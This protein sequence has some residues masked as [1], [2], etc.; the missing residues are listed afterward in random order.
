MTFFGKYLPTEIPRLNCAIRIYGGLVR[1]FMDIQI[2]LHYVTFF[3]IIFLWY[4]M[5]NNHCQLAIDFTLLGEGGD[6]KPNNSKGKETSTLLQVTA[7]LW[8]IMHIVGGI[9]RSMIYMDP[10][11]DIPDDPDTP[12]WKV[13]LF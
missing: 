9:I 12:G 6:I 3:Q 7:I 5:I 2:K 4:T 1:F 10:Y 8:F 11:Y 13:I